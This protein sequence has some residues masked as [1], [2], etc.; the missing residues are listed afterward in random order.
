MSGMKLLVLVS[1]S[2]FLGVLSSVLF[3]S[4]TSLIVSLIAG[5]CWGAF[6][7]MNPNLFPK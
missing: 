3:T 4:P 2:I 6:V 5:G 1:G 7:A